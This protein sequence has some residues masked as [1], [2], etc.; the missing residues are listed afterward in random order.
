MIRRIISIVAFTAAAVGCTAGAVA[1]GERLGRFINR[2][3][4]KI[5]FEL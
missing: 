5:R 1:L 4:H 3:S 2:M